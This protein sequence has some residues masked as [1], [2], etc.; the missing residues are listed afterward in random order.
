MNPVE[1][2]KKKRDSNKLTKQEIDFFIDGYLENKIP[3]YQMSSFLMSIF[4]SLMDE[5][6][7]FHLTEKMLHSG[8]I[9]DLS[10]INKVKV[11]KHSTGGVGDKTSIIL[12]PMVASCGIAVPMISGRGLGHTGG[13]LDKLESIPYFNVNLSLDDYKKVI[14]KIGV[15]MIGQTKEI[16][17]ADKRIYALRDV[18]A[19]IENISLISASIMSKKLAEGI[20]SLVLD[21]KTGTGAFMKS[22]DESVNLAKSLVKIGN[23]MQKKTVAYIT[24]M[25][26]VLGFAVGNW[27]E[28]VECIKC[29][30]NEIVVS[31]LMEVTYLL[32]GTM[33]KLGGVASSIEDGI[34]KCQEVIQ[35]G[36]AYEK[37][38]QIVETQNGDVSFIENIEKYPTSKFEIEIFSNENGFISDIN[39]LEIG[40]SAILIGAGRMKIDDKIDYKSGIVMNKKVGDKIHKGELLVK[41][42]T[43]NKSTCDIVK[44]RIHNAI[45]IVPESTKP[46]QLVKAYIDEN[47]NVNFHF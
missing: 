25:D 20:D 15:V 31:D 41:F 39:S 17:P 18:T 4:F 5:E 44:Q 30:R 43:D 42:F 24:S 45:K 6:E 36:K 11:D 27:L 32:G 34:K 14:E 3:E 29:L 2:I 9:V 37:F 40:L 12:A 22:F 19:T 13:T 21:V 23:M 26:D 35:N 7:T 38:L 46:K 8:S 47:T 33:L 1:I 10:N 28:I 16:A